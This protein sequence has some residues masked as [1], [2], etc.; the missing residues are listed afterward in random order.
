LYVYL[1]AEPERAAVQLQERRR[2]AGGTGTPGSSPPLDD[3]RV[4]AVLV[5]VIGSP[6]DSPRVISNRLRS[7]GVDVGEEQVEA[8]FRQYKVKKTAHSPSPRSRR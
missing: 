5:A 1:N 6:R 3:A 4:I 7:T 8:V 2:G